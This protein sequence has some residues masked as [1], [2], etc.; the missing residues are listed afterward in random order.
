MCKGRT[1]C[2]ESL[3]KRD[4]LSG[5][6]RNRRGEGGRAFFAIDDGVPATMEAGDAVETRLETTGLD[7]ARPGDAFAER[8]LLPDV[9]GMM[10]PDRPPFVML[11][12][13]AGKASL[14]STR[15]EVINFRWTTRGN[16]LLN[17]FMESTASC[18]VGIVAASDAADT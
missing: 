7:A 16:P 11:R 18:N 1:I 5:V 13:V 15:N 2:R 4:E 12:C 14:S 10:R 9:G 17:C 6:A 3:S 8:L